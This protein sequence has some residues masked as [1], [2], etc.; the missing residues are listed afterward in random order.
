MLE[1]EQPSDFTNGEMRPRKEKG[2]VQ[3]HK[4]NL[5]NLGSFYHTPFS[6]LPVIKLLLYKT[7]RRDVLYRGII[8]I[9]T[10][11]YI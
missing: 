11:R 10:K 5:A 1:V 3:D 4:V 7:T 8:E 2:L 9:M 6:N